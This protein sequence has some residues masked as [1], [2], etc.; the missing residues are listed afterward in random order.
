MQSIAFA[1]PI[2]PGKLE[3]AHDIQESFKGERKAA[4]EASRRRH[5]ITREAAFIQ[6]TPAGDLGVVYIEADDVAKAFE[7]LATSTDP[8]DSWFRGHVMEL[9]GIDLTKGFPPPEITIDYRG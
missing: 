8:F 7:G 1:A 4:Y 2:L 9:Q 3:L 6:H 5:G